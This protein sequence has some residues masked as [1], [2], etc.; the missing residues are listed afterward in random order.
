MVQFSDALTLD[1]P[2]KLRDGYLV[3][4]ALAARA[5]VY[6]YL[7]SE[8]DPQGTKFKPNDVVKVYRPAEEVFAADSVASFFAKPITNDHPTVSVTADNWKQHTRGAVM[9]A[10]RRVIDKDEYLAFDLALMDAEA[11]NAV[12]SGKRELSNGYACDLAFEDGVAPD[13]TAYQAVQRN[14][15]GNH[16]AIVDRGRAGSQCRIGD[17]A[18]QISDGGND[19]SAC[20]A[21][22]EIIQD[23][24]RT[25]FMNF[26]MLDELKVD[27]A[28]A[29]AVKAAV[30]K[31]Q[32]AKDAAITAKDEAEAKVAT[33]TTESATK[34]AKIVTLEKQIEDAKLTPAKLR[35]AAKAYAL[36]VDKAKA[37]GVTVTDEMDEAAIQKAVVTAKL[38]DAAKD[39]TADQIAVSFATMT[40]DAKIEPKHDPISAPRAFA[41]DNASVRNFARASQY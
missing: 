5:G 12:E 30:T 15:R 2:R 8:V 4:Q 16:V 41:T 20:D 22:P 35:E 36:T 28:D 7:G 33:L 25:R 32:A 1:A 3:A 18:P 17:G 19:W 26:I 21:I 27:L 37:L 24:K 9:G 34:D 39:W 38:G 40:A 14:I 6:D 13:G 31:L 29:D 11:I 10:K 23:L